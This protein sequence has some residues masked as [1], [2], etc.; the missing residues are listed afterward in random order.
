MTE[1][2]NPTGSS[3][4]RGGP[5][6]RGTSAQSDPGATCQCAACGV[7]PGLPRLRA[8]LVTESGVSAITNRVAQPTGS[9]ISSLSQ[10]SRKRTPI[11]PRL[12]SQ[13][14]ELGVPLWVT[15]ARGLG[16][17]CG[18]A[19][20]RKRVAVPPESDKFPRARSTTRLGRASQPRPR[21]HTVRLLTDPSDRRV[22]G[23]GL[24]TAV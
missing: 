10:M 22:Y 1:F 9:G 24:K 20:A 18:S 6:G 5:R 11:R 14:S 2:S 3:R 21:G 17:R 23:S 12:S 4:P 15:R 16:S 13:R 19:R 7:D 8:L